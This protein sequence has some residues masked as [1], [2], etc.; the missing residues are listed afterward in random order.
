VNTTDIIILA[1]MAVAAMAS[2]GTFAAIAKYLFDRGLADQNQAAP[3]IIEFYKTYLAHTRKTTGR[4][5]GVF[6]VHSISVGLF[7]A[8]GVVYSIVRFILPRLMG[9]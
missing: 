4:V 7:I 8:T 9:P 1:L 6:W 2:A 3:N 5:G